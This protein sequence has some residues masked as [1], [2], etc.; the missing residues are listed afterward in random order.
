MAKYHKPTLTAGLALA[1]ALTLSCSGDGGSGDNN[2]GGSSSENIASSSSDAASG[3]PSSSGVSSSVVSSSSSEVSSSSVSSSSACA[4]WEWKV[5]TPATCETSQTTGRAKETE[6]CKSDPS[7]TRGEPREKPDSE[8][9]WGEWKLVGE[10]GKRYCPDDPNCANNTCETSTELQR[11]GTKL[12]SP[13]L[14][15]CQ[16]PDVVEELCGTATFTS[17]QFCQSPDV[18]EELCGT[19][20]FTSAQ[21]CQ[22]GT[23]AVKDLCGTATYSSTQFC[24]AGTNAILPLCGTATFTSTQFC[25]AGTNAVLPLCGT[26]TFTSTQ[27]CQAGTNAILP[28]CGTATFTSTQFCY[29]SSKVGNLCGNRTEHYDPDLYECKPSINANGIYLKGGVTDSRGGTSKT[30]DAVLIGTR[31]WMAENLNYNATGS[32]CYAAGVSGVSADSIA[33]NCTAYGRLY[34]FTTAKTACPSGWRLPTEQEWNTLKTFVGTDPG[35]KLKANSASWNNNGK[36]T[37]DFGFSAL[38]G[39]IDFIYTFQDVGDV[40]YW[41]YD[42]PQQGNAYIMNMKYNS[43]QVSMDVFNQQF[44]LSVR[45]IQN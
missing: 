11:C 26:A 42:R 1:I 37:D 29:N 13:S 27:F 24:Q 5:T 31:T 19:A 28:L 9:E 14:Q 20:T 15:F 43:A 45:C 3:N 17:A 30:Y 35:T 12:Y 44:L 22:S 6:T 33:K 8:L 2:P 36:G 21:F 34:D 39:G 23:N 25:Q 32:K 16:S 4:E 18:V 40:G 10:V 41:W 7:I 38:P